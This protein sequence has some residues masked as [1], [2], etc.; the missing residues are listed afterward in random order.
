MRA[1]KVIRIMVAMMLPLSASSLAFSQEENG[2][3]TGTTL[4][5]DDN[6]INESQKIKSEIHEHS[7]C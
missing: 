6:F 3:M 2:I 1:G 5:Y 4:R 7:K